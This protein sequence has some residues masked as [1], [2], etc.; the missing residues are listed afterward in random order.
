MHGADVC[1]EQRIEGVFPI[2][3][4]PYSAD[5]S[6]DY[7]TLACEALFVANSDVQGLIWPC[8]NDALNLLSPE[9][10]EK[11]LE[12]VATALDGR[13]I[14]FTVCCPGRNIADMQRR[15]AVAEAVAA[16][17]PGLPAALLIRLANDAKG[18]ADYVRQFDA[19]AAATSLPIIVQAYNGQSPMPSAEMLVD[20]ARRHPETFGWFKVEGT[21]PE[22]VP[23]KRALVAAMPVVKTV[24]TGWGGRDW[25]YDFRCIGTRGVISQR[26]MLADLM[27]AVWRA[28]VACDPA[29]DGLFAR[30]MH[31][32]NLEE[33]LPAPELRGWNLY[34]LKRRGI[35]ANT[36]SRVR[37]PGGGWTLADLALTDSD[38]AEIDARLDFVLS[39]LGE[40][41]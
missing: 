21:G 11:G 5:G 28:L 13:G 38:R 8:A 23:C 29:A 35:F 2:L 22:I 30:F 15:V 18:D 37:Q 36:L 16:R 9:E 3:C 7:V 6:L 27:V 12:A 32:R 33:T 10:I 4:T 20:L 31:L 41:P 1:P 40:Q 25:L 34:V 19:L 17:H 26:P 39:P 14:L 24:F